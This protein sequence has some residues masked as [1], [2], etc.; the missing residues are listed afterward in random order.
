VTATHPE[1]FGFCPWGCEKLESE[2]SRPITALNLQPKT[3][4]ERTFH[5]VEEEPILNFFTAPLVQ[6]GTLFSNLLR[7]IDALL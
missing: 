7:E 1:T 3:R 5:L 2:R 6:G 4:A